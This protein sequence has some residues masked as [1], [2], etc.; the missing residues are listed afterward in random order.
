MGIDHRHEIGRT[1]AGKCRF[2]KMRV[3]GQEI[4]GLRVKIGE[5]AA[6]AAGNADLFPRCSTLFK[7]SLSLFAPLLFF[8]AAAMSMAET[9]R[10]CGHR[11]SMMG[12]PKPETVC[13][14]LPRNPC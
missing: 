13:P 1:E 9:P 8:I 12:D 6:A 2:G 10:Q 11:M 7:R 5:I 14:C 3:V 4:P